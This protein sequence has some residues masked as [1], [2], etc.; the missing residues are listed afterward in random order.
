MTST[1]VTADRSS[2]TSNGYHRLDGPI[3]RLIPTGT[4]WCGCGAEAARGAYFARGH[5]KKAEADLLRLFYPNGVA[6]LLFRHGF[7]PER[8]LDSLAVERGVRVR[9][10]DCSRSGSETDIRLH[11]MKDHGVVV[12]EDHRCPHGCVADI[13]TAAGL[14]R[15]LRSKHKGEG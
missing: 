12:D 9:C 1:R 11:R 4:C 5:D 14:Q 10:Q 15:H 8:S 2:S 7:G 6:E 3:P 13:K